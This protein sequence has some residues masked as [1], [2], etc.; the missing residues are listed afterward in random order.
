MT[1][2]VED[3]VRVK[4]ARAIEMSTNKWQMEKWVPALLPIMNNITM[5]IAGQQIR[6]D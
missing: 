2:R 1:T 3:L 6:Y 4:F 5:D